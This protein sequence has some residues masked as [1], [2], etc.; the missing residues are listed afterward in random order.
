MTIT[1]TITFLSA[2]FLFSN[3]TYGYTDMPD[4]SC[5]VWAHYGSFNTDFYSGKPIL[6]TDGVGTFNL[7]VRM[8]HGSLAAGKQAGL[9]YRSNEFPTWQPAT[10]SQCVNGIQN[11]YPSDSDQCLFIVDSKT[12]TPSG[13]SFEFIPFVVD[14]DKRLFDHNGVDSDIS[15]NRSLKSLN[16]R[17]EF[18]SCDR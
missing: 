7:L 15:E 8:P 16:D 14:G 2:I 1:K 13:T 5:Q 10:P 17:F 9:L 6:N 3:I 12:M 18:Y 4:Q 11:G